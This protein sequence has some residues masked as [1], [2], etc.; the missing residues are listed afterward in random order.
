MRGWARRVCGSR[1]IQM[2]AIRNQCPTR[3]GAL[4]GAR[5][6]CHQFGPCTLLWT[7]PARLAGVLSVDINSLRYSPWGELVY[8]LGIWQ[9]IWGEK[10]SRGQF[11]V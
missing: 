10:H 6:R 7:Y 4:V 5:G 1:D 9:L 11:M 2:L 8:K 3:T